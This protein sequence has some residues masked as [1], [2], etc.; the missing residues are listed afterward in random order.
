MRGSAWLVQTM[1]YRIG[2]TCLELVQGNITT[3]DVDAIV[4]AANTSLLGGGGV[5]GAIHRAGGPAILEGCRAILARQG[6]C[7]T[8]E[9]VITVGGNLAAPWVIHTVGPVWQGGQRGER[10]LLASAHRKSLQLAASKQLRSVAF[11]A[12][13]TGAYRFP[14]NEAARIAVE[15]I[16]MFCTAQPSALERVELVLFSAEDLEC[17]EEAARTQLEP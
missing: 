14:V 6:K 9:A 3:R 16:A 11:P 15:T 7:A 17:Y 13:S 4:N 5:D 1:Q 12:I 8:G 2:K 10:Q